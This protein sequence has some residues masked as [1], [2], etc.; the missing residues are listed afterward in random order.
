[1]TYLPFAQVRNNVWSHVIPLLPL[2]G[3][4]TTVNSVGSNPFFAR[5]DRMLS[6]G[7]IRTRLSEAIIVRGA[8]REAEHETSSSHEC[9]MYCVLNT[10]DDGDAPFL[11]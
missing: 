9:S 11:L 3:G 5:C 4:A 6:R 10:C 7:C 2:L 1:M 8:R